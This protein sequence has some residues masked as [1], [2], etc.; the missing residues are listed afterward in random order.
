MAEYTKNDQ[1][2]DLPEWMKRYDVS[3]GPYD[4]P[5]PPSAPEPSDEH[6]GERDSDRYLEDHR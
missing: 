5:V 3:V 4:Q 6:D 2:P 1:M